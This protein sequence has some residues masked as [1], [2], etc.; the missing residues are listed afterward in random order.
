MKIF[1]VRIDSISDTFC[2]I[3]IS[4]AVAL[5]TIMPLVSGEQFLTA[6]RIRLQSTGRGSWVYSGLDHIGNPSSGLVSIGEST[7]NVRPFSRN[8]SV[9]EIQY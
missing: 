8:A 2:R 4:S 7:S 1:V 6:I 3:A 5:L 9:N